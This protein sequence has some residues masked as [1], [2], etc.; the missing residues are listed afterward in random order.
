MT[1]LESALVIE[2]QSCPNCLRDVPPLAD[3]CPY[4]Q[5]D[6]TGLG[7]WKPVP[8]AAAAAAPAD[9]APLEDASFFRTARGL[10]GLILGLAFLGFIWSGPRTG[11]DKQLALVIALV[12]GAVLVVVMRA[13]YWWAWLLLF[14][15]FAFVGGCTAMFAAHFQ[16][17]G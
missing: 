5:A 11:T 15:P 7:G 13:R 17:G 12:L 3:R 1:Q 2:G 16:W 14:S 9:G 6:F 8:R 4:C 10:V